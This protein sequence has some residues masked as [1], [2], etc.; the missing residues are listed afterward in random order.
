MVILVS[1]V[2]WGVKDMQHST[3]TVENG[4]SVT[5]TVN[6]FN[7]VQSIRL[8]AAAAALLDDDELRGLSVDD[9]ARLMG[10]RVI[11]ADSLSERA[12][13]VLV[14]VRE[15][16][17]ARA[18]ALG[19]AVTEGLAAAAQGAD[20]APAVMVLQLE[21]EETPL[22]ALRSAVAARTDGLT[23]ESAAA[24]S[25]QE[26]LYVV[27]SQSLTWEDGAFS[28]DVESW[29]CDTGQDAERIAADYAGAGAEAAF[30]SRLSIYEDQLAYE[31]QLQSGGRQSTH[32][33]SAATGEIL[34]PVIAAPVVSP[35]Q[36]TP[37]EPAPETPAEP[38]PAEEPTPVCPLDPFR[39][40]FQ[41]VRDFF[42]W[43][44]AII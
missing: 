30:H 34:N 17:D 26:L 10:A 7:R 18:S 33:V 23:P 31:V 42:D 9:A 11:E 29:V 13:G 3:V 2:F 35:G 8:N 1:G 16:R 38:A 20:F 21:G 44:D 41:G 4:A 37:S 25:L 5:M 39:C 14:A 32:W 40:N 28:G 12:N 22:Q 43:I 15:A 24:L 27:D 6:G 19:Q 36:T